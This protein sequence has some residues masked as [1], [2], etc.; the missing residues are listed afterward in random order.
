MYLYIYL[1]PSHVI[2]PGEQSRFQGISS[3]ISHCGINTLKKCTI[4]ITGSLSSWLQYPEVSHCGMNTL[5]KCTLVR[6]AVSQRGFSTLK[7]RTFFFDAAGLFDWYHCFYLQRS[8]E[9]VSPVCRICFTKWWSW[10]LE[11][12]LSTGPTLSSFLIKNFPH[13]YIII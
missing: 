12:L 8:R 13:E 4:I 7:K 3:N 1:S 2:V 9:L 5:K 6:L 11:G 10:S